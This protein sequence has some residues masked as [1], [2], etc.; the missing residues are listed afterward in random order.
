[1]NKKII[2]AVFSF[3]FLSSACASIYTSIERQEDGSYTLTEV[4]QGFFSVGSKIYRCSESSEGLTC[5]PL[6]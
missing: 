2:A 5:K 4:R 3:A 6:N 1:M